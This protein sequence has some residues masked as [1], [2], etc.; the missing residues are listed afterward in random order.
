M[1]TLSKIVTNKNLCGPKLT[2]EKYQVTIANNSPKVEDNFDHW[3]SVEIA[4][5]GLEKTTRGGYQ[6]I[7]RWSDHR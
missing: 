2:G 7:V 3:D 4:K 6:K 1:L 5:Y